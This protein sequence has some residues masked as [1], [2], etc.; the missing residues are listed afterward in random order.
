MENPKIKILSKRRFIQ[1]W[2]N[3]NGTIE[4]RHYYL[5]NKL[6]RKDGP[7]IIY[8]D[9]NGNIRTKTYYLNGVKH[10]TDGPAIIKYYQNQIC[11]ELYY[12]N[13]ELH[14]V[15]GPSVIWY[16]RVGKISREFYHLNNKQLTKEEFDK[17]L[18]K[19]KLELI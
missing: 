14:R 9:N 10:R 17:T 11:E 1:I 16:R 12:L 5:D 13:N 8:Y 4:S 19:K 6:H 2:Y 7:A 18:L 3:Q 15:D